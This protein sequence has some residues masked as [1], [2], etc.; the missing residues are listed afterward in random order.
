[1]IAHTD[2]WLLLWRQ[3][4]IAVVLP[5]PTGHVRDDALAEFGSTGDS[6][7]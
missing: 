2:A 3:S 1:M 7:V 4:R 5:L 6:T